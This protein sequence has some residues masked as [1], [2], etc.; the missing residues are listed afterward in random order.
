MDPL[1]CPDCIRLSG[2]FTNVI[3]GL[4]ALRAKEQGEGLDSE[5]RQEIRCELDDTTA[6]LIE[7]RK[8]ILGHE[9]A[10]RCQGGPS[11]RPGLSSRWDR[12]LVNR[13]TYVH[14]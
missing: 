12:R 13:R 11:G 5:T 4:S 10:H 1:A 7:L 6:D 8:W 9:A 3:H 2:L 14:P